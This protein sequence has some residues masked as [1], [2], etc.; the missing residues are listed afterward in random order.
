[1]SVCDECYLYEEINRNEERINELLKD[2]E[3]L[4]QIL[5][6]IQDVPVNPFLR[7]YSKEEL[8][9]RIQRIATLALRRKW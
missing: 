2:I 9:E 7:Q 4:E 3:Y 1:M 6:E 8:L 5:S